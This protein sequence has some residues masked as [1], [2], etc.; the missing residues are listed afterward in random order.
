[1]AAGD[2]LWHLNED[3]WVV[4]PSR[5]HASWYLVAE[6]KVYVPVDAR[7]DP[8]DLTPIDYLTL[9]NPD[10][11]VHIEDPDGN[12]YNETAEQFAARGPTGTV[13]DETFDGDDEDEDDGL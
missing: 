11:D 12:I 5:A 3:V 4:A 7:W 9:C 1:M 2:R 6:A 10:D 8:D 13:V